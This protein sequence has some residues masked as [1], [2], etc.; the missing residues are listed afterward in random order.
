MKQKNVIICCILAALAF[1]GC[2][3]NVDIEDQGD[4]RKLVLYC[5]LCPQMDTTYILLSNTQ[6]I[7]GHDNQGL[8]YI[9]DGT[10]ELSA[11]GNHWVQAQFDPLLKRYL[12]TK[13]A[14][15]VVE[16]G[17]Y[18]IRASHPDYE[19]VSASCTVPLTHDVGFRYDTV[20]T[21]GDVHWGEPYNL[22]HKDLYVEWRDVAGEENAYA[23][24]SKD[25][26]EISDYDYYSDEYDIYYEWRFN[27]EWMTENNRDYLYVSDKGRDGKTMRF[28]LAV[29]IEDEG[30][31]YD[32]EE[33]INHQTYL[34]FLDKNC[35]Q[36]EMTLPL[37]DGLG[38]LSFLFLEPEHTYNNIKN[39]F[40]LFGAFSM[41]PV[42]PTP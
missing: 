9:T 4:I 25:L 1:T 8:S 6:S 22:P 19:E 14:F 26:W 7:F 18:H 24:G 10:V 15:P 38:M 27:L 32:D 11:D 3:D 16:G 23:L 5:R 13:K 42:N 2:V 34:F 17:T 20:S 21:D 31:W 29:G 30:D 39:G 12:I 37:L 41:L 33:N 35:Y 28:L 36:Y 40:G